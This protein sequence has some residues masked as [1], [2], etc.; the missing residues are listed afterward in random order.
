LTGLAQPGE[1]LISTDAAAAAG[2]ETDGLQRR[3]L[4][5]RGREQAVD[6][7]VARAGN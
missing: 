5:L 6:A 1:I 2:L 7:W 3:S 4:E